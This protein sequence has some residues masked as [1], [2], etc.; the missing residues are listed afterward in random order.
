MGWPLNSNPVPCFERDET[1]NP[2]IKSRILRWNS[3]FDPERGSEATESKGEKKE[4]RSQYSEDRMQNPEE[5]R[6]GGHGF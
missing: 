5:R 4:V 2:L 1:W 3:A 6:S